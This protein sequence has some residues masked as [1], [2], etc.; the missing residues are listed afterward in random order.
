[1][2]DSKLTTFNAGMAVACISFRTPIAIA[3]MR[4]PPENRP[5][6]STLPDHF[7]VPS[8]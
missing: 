5:E 6:N 4:R 2:P 7:P 3:H 1:M 8:C